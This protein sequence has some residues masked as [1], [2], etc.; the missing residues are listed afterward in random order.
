MRIDFRNRN[1][2]V[3]LTGQRFG[4]LVVI[5]KGGTAGRVYWHCRCD[6]GEPALV[7]KD[8][9]IKDARK[10]PH[11]CPKCVAEFVAERRKPKKA[12]GKRCDHGFTIETIEC[13]YGCSLADRI[14][15]RPRDNVL[16]PSVPVCATCDLPGHVSKLCPTTKVGKRRL[17]ESAEACRF[18]GRMTP[19]QLDESIS[20]GRDEEAVRP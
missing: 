10:V 19:P 18:P 8:T 7:S 5:R 12:T 3:D 6:C 17:A 20:A 13:P 16:G 9:L 1:P 2:T 11:A 4:K 14:E 15:P